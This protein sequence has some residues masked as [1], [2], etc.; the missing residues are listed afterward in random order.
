[1]DTKYWLSV[2]IP[3]HSKWNR[4]LQFLSQSETT[5]IPLI[6]TWESRPPPPGSE[7]PHEDLVRGRWRREEGDILG[8]KL[9]KRSFIS[10]MKRRKPYHKG[11][12][13]NP[14][15][16]LACVTGARKNGRTRGRRARAEGAPFA[17]LPL[18]CPFFLAP[19]TSKRLLRRLR[20]YI[21]G[22]HRTRGGSSWVGGF[23]RHQCTPLSTH[24][25]PFFTSDPGDNCHLCSAAAKGRV[26]LQLSLE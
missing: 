9:V 4:A 1:M 25:T 2:L 5:S 16:L 6:F 19:T 10:K 17:C 7:T 24:Y 13:R 11:R 26:F 20:T 12:D 3:E 18:A 22:H 23:L 21:R 14:Q 15:S 8:T